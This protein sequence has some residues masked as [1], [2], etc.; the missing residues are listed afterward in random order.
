MI[1]QAASGSTTTPT[2][3]PTAR[4]CAKDK[5]H[6]KI[7]RIAASHRRYTASAS[8]THAARRRTTARRAA[9]AR[10]NKP[11]HK[12]GQRFF[13]SRSSSRVTLW[14]VAKSIKRTNERRAPT[15]R[16]IERTQTDETTLHAPWFGG[17]RAKASEKTHDP[18]IFSNDPWRRRSSRCSSRVARAVSH[19]LVRAHKT[20]AQ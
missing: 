19:R 7:Q 12:F 14:G 1:R 10:R 8:A 4:S 18:R 11:A 2:D 9:P 15:L 20:R 3:R 6:R 5:R 16:T 17:Q 13:A